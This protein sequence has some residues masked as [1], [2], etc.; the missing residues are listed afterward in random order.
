MIKRT[1]AW[2]GRIRRLSKVYE[3]LPETGETMVYIATTRLTL[4]RLT[5][6]KRR[7]KAKTRGNEKESKYDF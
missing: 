1:V 3:F 4:K 6:G 2:L 7:E 5:E